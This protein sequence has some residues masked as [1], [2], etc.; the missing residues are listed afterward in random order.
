MRKF[1]LAI[2]PV[3]L[4]LVASAAGAQIAPHSGDVA[5][6]AGYTNI[7]KG[8]NFNDTTINRYT[9]GGSGGVNLNSYLTV[10]GEFNFFAMPPVDGVNENMTNYGGAVRFNL[11]S[12][13]KVIP[14]GIFGGGGDRL[15]ASESGASASANG[16]YFGG[17]GGASIFLGRSWGIRPE[18]RFNRFNFTLSGVSANTNVLTASGGVFFQFGGTPKR[19]AS[20]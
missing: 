20:R 4:L 8:T 11:A 5:F 9:F 15:T 16:D 6:D 13:G 10:I 2:M 7:G 1:I 14:Y 19:V 3:A 12:K 18:F 17:G